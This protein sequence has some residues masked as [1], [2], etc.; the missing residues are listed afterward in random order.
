MKLRASVW[1]VDPRDGEMRYQV[2][3]LDV[4]DPRAFEAQILDEELQARGVDV[5]VYFGPIGPPWGKP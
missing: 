3:E 4:T 1:T 5:E 2:R